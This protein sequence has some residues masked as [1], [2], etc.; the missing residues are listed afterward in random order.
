[1]GDGIALKPLNVE[2]NPDSSE[3]GGE[4]AH[5]SKQSQHGE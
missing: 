5:S 1:M 4:E 2:E 3:G